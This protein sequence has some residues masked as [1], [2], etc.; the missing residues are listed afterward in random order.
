MFQLYRCPVIV[1]NN[2]TEPSVISVN[3]TY[4]VPDAFNQREDSPKIGSKSKSQE[5]EI[6]G[7][8]SR[9]IFP[10]LLS[11]ECTLYIGV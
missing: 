4:M 11:H 2:I 10:R 8:N 6:L 1:V 9:V 3:F 7:V 5:M